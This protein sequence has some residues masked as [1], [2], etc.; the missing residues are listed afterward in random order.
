MWPNTTPRFLLQ[1]DLNKDSVSR[2]TTPF[3][4]G[5]AQ[6]R[7]SPGGGIVMYTHSEPLNL[8]KGGILARA[9]LQTSSDDNMPRERANHKKDAFCEAVYMENPGQ[10]DPERASK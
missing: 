5:S 1:E 9:P 6:A 8:E 3:K 2:V 7:P 4:A 10:A